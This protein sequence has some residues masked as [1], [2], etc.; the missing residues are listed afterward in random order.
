MVSNGFILFIITCYVVAAIIGVNVHLSNRNTNPPSAPPSPNP[1][2]PTQSPTL[3]PTVFPTVSPTQSPTNVPVN[4]CDTEYNN[5]PITDAHMFSEFDL[6]DYAVFG[7]P[8]NVSG[9]TFTL[10]D[11]ID[12][13]T[14]FNLSNL[15]EPG[16]IDTPEKI[17]NLSQS[18]CFDYYGFEKCAGWSWIYTDVGNG[19]I[20]HYMTLL[21]NLYLARFILHY[22]TFF[23]L[24][25][26]T[27][28]EHRSQ[29]LVD[30]NV[31]LQDRVAQVP[32]GGVDAIPNPEY[33]IYE[34]YTVPTLEDFPTAIGCNV[35]FFDQLIQDEIFPQSG[36]RFTFMCDYDKIN[37]LEK[38]KRTAQELCFSRPEC[39][40]FVVLESPL[41]NLDSWNYLTVAFF[42]TMENTIMLHPLILGSDFL[43]DHNSM[44]G[45]SCDLGPDK[46]IP[47]PEIRCGDVNP[48]L[49]LPAF[50]PEFNEG[51]SFIP[52]FNASINDIP[53][54]ISHCFF[55]EN[56]VLDV[57][58]DSGNYANFNL[59][60][61][62]AFTNNGFLVDVD[63][64][65]EI[66][67]EICLFYGPHVCMGM[68][69][70]R[71]MDNF[72]Y[73][74]I[75]KTV[76]FDNVLVTSS[77]TLELDMQ[78]TTFISDAGVMNSSAFMLTSH[79]PL[80]EL[81]EYN[82]TGNPVSDN[83][84]FATYLDL[85][86]VPGDFVRVWNISQ[87]CGGD[88]TKEE[89]I[90]IAQEM[91]DSLTACLVWR[92]CSSAQLGG[93]LGQYVELRSSVA[94][95]IEDFVVLSNTDTYVGYPDISENA[96]GITCRV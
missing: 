94:D 85:P 5:A 32:P 6:F 42:L 56:D 15:C 62:C 68:S 33:E 88:F 92:L 55:T 51:D 69:W 80:H 1:N 38:R 35:T 30:Q 21:P 76:P 46:V 44:F 25:P 48:H 45:F 95:T 91:C 64:L 23:L 90:A 13:E 31:K 73:G 66:V 36:I 83:C 12:E 72:V 11:V 70:E 75:I 27:V 40:S 59:S 61:A 63:V 77:N 86:V 8:A 16:A 93:E 20:S 43:G 71:H 57:F 24:P 87:D 52:L 67:L 47:D 4:L 39:V 49:V 3:S 53:T 18:I 26:E 22:K 9:C 10:G 19:F 82:L 60:S 34:N 81:F 89:G 96:W 7:V 14:N 54:N 2:N 74:V 17:S 37:T 65:N 78:S 28:V 84:S 58:L 41:A 50:S 29:F 79:D